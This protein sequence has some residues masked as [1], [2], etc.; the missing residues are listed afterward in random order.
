M[1]VY[2]R[3]GRCTGTGNERGTDTYQTLLLHR[4]RTHARIP[5][6][7][8]LETRPRTF[9]MWRGGQDI[10]VHL[11]TGVGRVLPFSLNSTH[12]MCSRMV[13][14]M[15]GGRSG[16][17]RC[18]LLCNG[19]RCRGPSARSR[20]GDRARRPDADGCPA[21]RLCMLLLS[22]KRFWYPWSR[23]RCPGR[24]IGEGGVDRR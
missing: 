10:A 16:L 19:R 9:L 20:R 24:G 3:F 8:S 18:D 5:C 21:S 7:C 13:G 12:W 15:V 1:F 22:W 11:Q 2:G 4:S 23:C 17:C 14:C 6:L